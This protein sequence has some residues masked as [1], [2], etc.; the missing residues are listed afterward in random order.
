[1]DMHLTSILMRG[2]T[3]QPAA[4]SLELAPRSP[5]AIAADIPVGARLQI[6]ETRLAELWQRRSDNQAAA[7]A[8]REGHDDWRNDPRIGRGLNRLEAERL[9][10]EAEII[11][12]RQEAAPLRQARAAKIAEACEQMRTDSATRLLSFLAGSRTE[13]DLLNQIREV[14]ERAGGGEGE[15]VALP[16]HGQAEVLARRIVGADK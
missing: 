16:D 15:R 6:I 3:A 8:L 2:R 7:G 14:I 13:A 12:A 5:S 11:K 1:M 10:I 4:T 9:E